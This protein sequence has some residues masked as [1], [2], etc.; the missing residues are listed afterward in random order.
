MYVIQ[1]LKLFIFI[2]WS[3][4]VNMQIKIH[5]AHGFEIVF[6]ACVVFNSCFIVFITHSP[7]WNEAF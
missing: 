2:C 4:S 6:Q 3:Y 1:K 5:F 7:D